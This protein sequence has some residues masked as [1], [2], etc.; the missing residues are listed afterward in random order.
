MKC[1]DIDRLQP[2]DIILTASKSTT[3]KLVRLAS[4][5][6]VS[7]AMICVQH[8]SIIDSTSEGVQARN[9]QREFFSDDEQVS[10]FRLR[11]ALPPLEIQKVVDFARSE[12]GTRYSKIEAARSVAPIGKPRGRRQF[13]SRLVARAYASVGILLV[14]DQDYCT[15]EELRK[16]GLLQ[17]LDDIVVQVSA[18]EVAAMAARSNPL[19][20]M[21][22]AQNAIL[23][24]VRSLD[25][26]VENFT[27]VDRFVDE[28]PEWDGAIA[29][30][31]R[32]SGYL[33]LWEHELSSHP[34]RYDLALMEE[35]TAPRLVADLREYCVGT[36]REYYSGG[37]RFAVNLTYYEASQQKAPRETRGLL[38]DLY[39]TLVRDH[40]RRVETAR[41]W[42][43]KHFPHDVEEHLERIA[44]HTPLW[45]SI[46]DRV[47]PRLGAI[48]RLS[49]SREQSADVCSSC[50][51]P[52]KD[53]RIVNAAEAMPGVPS[54]RLCDDCVVIRRG[55][56][57]VLEAMD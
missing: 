42:L 37:V 6:D 51:D 18:E 23:T 33:D 50:G 43:A 48:A 44:P 54:L 7:H 36:I 15:P 45:F 10:A 13:C 2:G 53:F 28:H 26:E 55:F 3:G 31:Y 56:G 35:I 12:I 57:E 21:R 1:I 46:V 49:I 52:A 29:D 8:G 47:E 14:A 20:R 24:F 5:G 4:K 32:N 25:P 19:Q 30:A 17:E 38:I 34:Y 16:S 41:R 11:E 40:E 22:E 9:L 27:D 39:Q